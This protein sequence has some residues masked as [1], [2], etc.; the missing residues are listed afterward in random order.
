MSV[1]TVK[2]TYNGEDLILSDRAIRERYRPI[3]KDIPLDRFSCSATASRGGEGFFL[4]TRDTMQAIIEEVIYDQVEAD[5]YKKGKADLVFVAAYKE[6]DDAPDFSTEQLTFANV[7]VGPK[8]RQV[9]TGS[10]ESIFLLHLVDQLWRST[11]LR[12]MDDGHVMNMLMPDGATIIGETKNSGVAWTWATATQAAFVAMGLTSSTSTIAVPAADPEALPRDMEV[13]RWPAAAAMDHFCAL[14]GWVFAYDPFTT[15]CAIEDVL[16]P[17]TDIQTVVSGLAERLICGGLMNAEYN[18]QAYQ[19]IDA[20]EESH[21][22]LGS[23]LFSMPIPPNTVL[24]YRIHVR[25]PVRFSDGRYPTAADGS[26]DESIRFDE[27]SIRSIDIASS[28]HASLLAAMLDATKQI[29]TSSRILFGDFVVQI[30][31]PTT[32]FANQISLTARDTFIAKRVLAALVNPRG[33]LIYDGFHQIAPGSVLHG[34]AVGVEDG[35][36]FTRLDLERKPPSMFGADFEIETGGQGIMGVGNNNIIQ[37]SDG[38]WAN[39]A[40]SP[41]FP[42]FDET[43]A[44]DLCS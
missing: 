24:P 36:P 6:S 37:R 9:C 4:C 39:H 19:G 11:R 25:H 29:E 38:S 13:S 14:N 34:I 21:K 23:D 12:R 35:I 28:V 33:T 32:P 2:I 27:G 17:G 30:K 44:G 43:A 20:N 26:A 16:S 3:L 8:S 15:A 22:Y 42:F 7:Y 41:L 18:Y 10:G 31:A 40:N 1:R 5:G